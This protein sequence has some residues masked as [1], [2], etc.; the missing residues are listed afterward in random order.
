[1]TDADSIW[2]SKLSRLQDPNLEKM[3]PLVELVGELRERRQERGEPRTAAR[4]VLEVAPRRIYSPECVEGVFCE[5][6]HNGVLGSS[7]RGFL[8]KLPLQGRKKVASST[9]QLQAQKATYGTS[10]ESRAG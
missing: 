1:V 4:A 2:E 3:E 6:R 10:C 5:L 8:G 7:A 9:P